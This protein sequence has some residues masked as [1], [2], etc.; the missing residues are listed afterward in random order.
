MERHL[1]LGTKIIDLDYGVF[2]I[3]W[4]AKIHFDQW[5]YQILWSDGQISTGAHQAIIAD[6]LAGAVIIQ[7]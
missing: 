4:S 1:E 2:G 7:D 6:E 5:W 3:V